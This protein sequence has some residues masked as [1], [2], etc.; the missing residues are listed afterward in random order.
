M[1]KQIM[2]ST[3]LAKIDYDNQKGFFLNNF[4][5]DSVL[6]PTDTCLTLDRSIR[7]TE[8]IIVSWT[9]CEGWIVL[10]MDP[11]TQV[12]YVNYVPL[13][14]YLNSTFNKNIP[15]ERHDTSKEQL[16]DEY[17][18]TIKDRIQ[19]VTAF[20]NKPGQISM[21]EIIFILKEHRH[22]DTQNLYQ[23]LEILKVELEQWY[24]AK[25]K[26]IEY[27]TFDAATLLPNPPTPPETKSYFNY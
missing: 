15:Y 2:T 18:E 21:D 24:A 12:D 27:G 17:I 4:F 3:E 9:L 23:L 5:F 19:S 7:T 8:N 14:H 26:L 16:I 20:L 11:F 13:A 22:P 25:W 10:P 1:S 6:N